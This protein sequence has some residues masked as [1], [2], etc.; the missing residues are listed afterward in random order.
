MF[1]NL[2][3]SLL[4]QGRVIFWNHGELFHNSLEHS[5]PIDVSVLE[6]HDVGQPPIITSPHVPPKKLNKNNL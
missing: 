1:L 6:S 2:D 4:D 3:S 5:G